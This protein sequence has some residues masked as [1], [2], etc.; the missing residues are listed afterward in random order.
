MVI[1]MSMGHIEYAALH[2]THVFKLIGEVRAQACCSLDHL[3]DRLQRFADV[4]GAVG[5]LNDAK[6]I[7]STALGII[8][9]L[10]L[11]IR[12][13]HHVQ[14]VLLS[15][16]DDITT[17]AH[18]MGLGQIFMMLSHENREPIG[19]D[20]MPDQPQDQMDM[21]HTVLEAHRTLMALNEHNRAMFEPL[22]TQL[23]REEQR[24]QEAQ[25]FQ[26][27]SQSS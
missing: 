6:F 26:P 10:G 9:K 2:G 11:G 22:V 1:S 27:L 24:Q 5:D 3:L 4:R 18:S 12:R 23:E 17:L 19:L 8:A 20:A 14:P 16:Q 15:T 13:F 7:D 21:L 25:A